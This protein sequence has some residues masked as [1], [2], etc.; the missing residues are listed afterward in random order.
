MREEIALMN[1]IA[2]LLFEAKSLKDLE[3]SGYRFLGCGRESVADH[4][5]TT[6]VVAY[7]L[8]RLEPSVDAHKLITM[9]L[10]H[11]LPEARIG[12]INY[13]QRFYVA[14]DEEQAVADMTADLPFGDEIAAMIHE[15]NQG[16]T[17]EAQLARDADQLS[18]LLELKD[19]SD[20]GCQTPD[21]WIAN[22]KKRILT[23]IGRRLYDVI[24]ETDRDRWWRQK[25]VD[26]P[27]QSK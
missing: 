12:D 21:A 16:K 22:L 19:L 13:V 14:A 26:R 20:K 18:L 9:C 7:V 5:Y 23:P 11:D 1:A 6:S 4:S 2:D 24:L 15:F 3:R 17:A 25:F 8:S 27:E 10:L